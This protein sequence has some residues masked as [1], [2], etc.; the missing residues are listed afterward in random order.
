MGHYTL[1]QVSTKRQLSCSLKTKGQTISG[2]SLV[3]SEII[4]EI[5]VS[6]FLET[7]NSNIQAINILKPML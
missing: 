1:C 7:I 5:I 4:S 2:Y 3:L 6:A